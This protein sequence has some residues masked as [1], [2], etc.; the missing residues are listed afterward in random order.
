MDQSQPIDSELASSLRVM[1]VEDEAMIAMSLADVLE[2]MGHT[3][4]AIAAT[5]AEAVTAAS[6]CRP[7]LMIVDAGL[8]EG[9]GILAVEAIL[10]TGFVPHVFCTGSRLKDRLLHERAAVLQ[11]PFRASDLARA[12]HQALAPKGAA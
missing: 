1:V 12:M 5:E 4:C 10:R 6:R 3:V 2:D 9:S 11:K 7:D 8:R